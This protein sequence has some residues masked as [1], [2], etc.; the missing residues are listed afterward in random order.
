M[1]PVT[2]RVN[3]DLH[4]TASKHFHPGPHLKPVREGELVPDELVFKPRSRTTK[5]WV[6]G[7]F[8][9]IRS[10][11]N[12]T[13]DKT[14]EWCLVALDLRGSMS[15]KGDSGSI[16]IDKD[17]RPVAML[18]GGED[19]LFATGPRDVSYASPLPNIFRDIERCMQWAEGSVLLA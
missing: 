7:T 12:T 15:E 9:A 11:Q 17:F 13:G 1:H 5:K 2:A 16:I 8:N 18:W 4:S 6:A 14:R 10:T 3:E 19:H